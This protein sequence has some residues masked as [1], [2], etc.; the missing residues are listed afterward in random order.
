M[1]G[2]STVTGENASTVSMA[3]GTSLFRKL[4]S[5]GNGFTITGINLD[6]RFGGEATTSATGLTTGTPFPDLGLRFG[7]S[8]GASTF[9]PPPLLTNEDASS[10]L[11]YAAGEDIAQLLVVPASTSW[12]DQ[13]GWRMRVTLRYQFRLTA[14]S[15]FCLQVGNNSAGTVAFGFTGALRVSYA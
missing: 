15:D 3:T 5:V 1:P 12:Q 4:V 10:M 11:W 6:L 2:Y 13:Y 8:Y 14:A 9:T 7:L